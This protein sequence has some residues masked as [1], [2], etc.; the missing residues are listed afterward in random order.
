M[1]IAPPVLSRQALRDHAAVLLLAILV[2]AGTFPL[3]RMAP[4]LGFLGPFALWFGLPVLAYLLTPRNPV[5]WAVGLNLCTILSI[6]LWPNPQVP[7]KL[8]LGLLVLIA[9]AL[10]IGFVVGVILWD[11]RQQAKRSAR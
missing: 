11:R 6:V 8:G 4:R 2:T 5:G 9:P 10:V 1:V 3:L 7:D